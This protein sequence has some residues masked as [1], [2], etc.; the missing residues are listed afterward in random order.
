MM[1]MM[2]MMMM[3]ILLDHVVISE[4][5]TVLFYSTDETIVT[6][7]LIEDCRIDWQTDMSAPDDGKLRRCFQSITEA[8]PVRWVRT[9][10]PQ[11]QR[12]F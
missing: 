3:Q 7:W 2:M 9:N 11:R 1:M 6:K 10:P 8:D 4:D 5:V 12:N